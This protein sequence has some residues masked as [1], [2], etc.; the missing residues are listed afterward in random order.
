MANAP[1]NSGERGDGPASE[2][3]CT[4]DGNADAYLLGLLHAEGARQ[5]AAGDRLLN[6]R[7]TQE[8]I[9][10]MLVEMDRLASAT[11]VVGE[12]ITARCTACDTTDSGPCGLREQTLEQLRWLLPVLN[13]VRTR[14]EHLGAALDGARRSTPI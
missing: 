7:P 13:D 2:R 12:R 10:A 6:S 5:V 4:P 1:G 11:A 14:V 3:S 9:A 8:A